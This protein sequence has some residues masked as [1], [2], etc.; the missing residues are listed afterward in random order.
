MLLSFQV[1]WDFPANFLI[2]I[3][4]LILL[5]SENFCNW[6]HL[7]VI[8]F[9]VMVYGLFFWMFHIYLKAMCILL[10]LG[11]CQLYN[12]VD[13]T[14]QVLCILTDTLFTCINYWEKSVEITNS[15]HGFVYFSSCCVGFCFTYFEALLFGGTYTFR[16][17]K[18]NWLLYH[19]LFCCPS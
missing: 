3:S 13:S 14:V 16:F 15:R 19:Y 12:L 18:N 11:R 6:N 17:F 8:K 10:L 2:S 7:K 9:W 5:W 1:I 4:N